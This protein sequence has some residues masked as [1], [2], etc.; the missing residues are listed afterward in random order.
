MN[1]GSYDIKAS[2]TW[3]NKYKVHKFECCLPN[4]ERILI[5]LADIGDVDFSLSG[6]VSKL[7]EFSR[8]Q[9][10]VF[11]WEL[12][13]DDSFLV[14]VTIEKPHTYS[15]I[16]IEGTKGKFEQSRAYLLNCFYGQEQDDS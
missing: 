4:A 3:A 1:T 16:Y 11:D 13:G 6:F 15:K 5:A 14:R 10:K 2:E 9:D 8:S 12:R 7:D